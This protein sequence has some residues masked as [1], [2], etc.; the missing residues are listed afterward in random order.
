MDVSNN[1]Q[2]LF[3]NVGRSDEFPLNNIRK[4]NRNEL[5]IK[6][7][8]TH[9]SQDLL[10]GK[11]ENSA[12]TI[13][14]TKSDTNTGPSAI[15]YS[16]ADI[17]A[18][19]KKKTAAE[20]NEEHLKQPEVKAAI[21]EL[22]ATE[23]NVRAHEQAHIA[24][25]A[26]VTGAIS[27]SY[28]TGP[29]GKRYITGGEVSVGASGG[30]TPEE[31]LKQLEQVK[32]AALAPADP[33]PQDLSVAAST[34]AQIMQVRGELASKTKEELNNATSE[35]KSVP[36]VDKE[37]SNDLSTKLQITQTTKNSNASNPSSEQKNSVRQSESNGNEQQQRIQQDIEKTML[38]RAYNQA[39]SKYKLQMD[40]SANGF[41][42]QPMFSHIA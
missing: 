13:T 33:S 35:K 5:A 12:I 38:E 8:T 31:T 10:I 19:Y 32:H 18:N 14:I 30:S 15:T 16:E 27:Y 7:S 36:L 34:S 9:A 40:I 6:Q 11:Q 28:T 37:G 21:Q 22:R 26:G 25:G 41:M 17:V 23:Q 4:N 20:N 2:S 42:Q 29:D 1:I 3:I 39:T 24:A